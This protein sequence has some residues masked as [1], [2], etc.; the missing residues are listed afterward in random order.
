MAAELG[1]E[2]LFVRA[3]SQINWAHRPASDYV[4]GV[5]LALAAGAH[6]QARSLA[7]QGAQRYPDHV[8]LQKMARILAPPRV[9]RTGLPADPSL[10][11][12]RQ[13]LQANRSRYAGRWIALKQGRLLAAGETVSELRA[14]LG[15]LRG[16]LV[17]KVS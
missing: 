5:R 7:T 11:A 4:R 1:N 14:K 13:W 12:D 15:D 8:E 6:L 10:R 17:T 9:V 16:T 3:L 2:V